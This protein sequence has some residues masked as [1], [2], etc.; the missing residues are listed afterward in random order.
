MIRRLVICGAGALSIAFGCSEIAHLGDPPTVFFPVASDSA[1]EES[2]NPRDSS[3]DPTS[4]TT[5]EL[6]DAPETSADEDTT[7][8]V[9]AGQET[10]DASPDIQDPNARTPGVQGP[11]AGGP[12]SS[13]LEMKRRQQD[14]GSGLYPITIGGTAFD[15]YCNMD[16]DDGGWTTFF[17]QQLGAPHVVA[18]FEDVDAYGNPK[19][20]CG[21]PAA[22]C[23]RHIPS[24]VTVANQFAVQCGGDALRFSVPPW[25]IAY[26]GYGVHRDWQPITGTV[27]IAGHPV[28]PLAQWFYT[29]DPPPIHVNGVNGWIMSQYNL[30]LSSYTFASSSSPDN[31]GWDFC[32]GVDYNDAGQDATANPFV[33]LFYR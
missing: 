29:G 1:S 7:R 21:S 14:A 32:N 26:W 4:E 17:V 3:L 27:S 24:A 18:Q 13:C 33:W 23:L 11:D 5:S 12:A 2:D 31:P 9:D 19:D 20:T 16:M 30:F 15:T 6:L 22:S 8:P 28:L 10:T 25:V